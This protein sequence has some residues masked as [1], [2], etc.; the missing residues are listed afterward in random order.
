MITFERNDLNWLPF[1]TGVG[2]AIESP[3]QL[4]PLVGRLALLF[5]N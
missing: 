1:F 4:F 2:L 3:A 5:R